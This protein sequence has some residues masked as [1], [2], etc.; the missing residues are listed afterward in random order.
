MSFCF[1]RIW[2]ETQRRFLLDTY[3]TKWLSKCEGSLLEGKEKN[4]YGL[5][6]NKCE[7]KEHIKER[8]KIEI[9]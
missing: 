9:K 5:M 1:S 3:L 4:N 8:K 7:I 2:W 6:M